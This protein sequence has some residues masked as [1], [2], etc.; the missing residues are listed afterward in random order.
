MKLERLGFTHRIRNLA[1]LTSDDESEIGRVIV[2][3]KERYI[4]QSV[5][6]SL[7]DEITGNLSV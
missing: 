4:I 7:N 5:E 6:G 3:H 2:E 1:N